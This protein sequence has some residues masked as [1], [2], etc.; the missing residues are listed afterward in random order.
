MP[1]M[2]RWRRKALA[3]KERTKK[4]RQKQ[5]KTTPQETIL[6]I[7]PGTTPVATH[8]KTS[9]KKIF[10]DQMPW[11]L[12][13]LKKKTKG[14]KVKFIPGKSTH[15]NVKDK[16]ITRVECRMALAER[17]SKKVAK[18][19]K[20]IYRVL[21]PKGIVSISV[22]DFFKDAIINA[23]KNAGFSVKKVTPITAETMGLFLKGTFWERRVRTKLDN[24]DSVYYLK[25]QK[26]T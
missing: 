20:E 13:E 2:E 10:L 19:I 26:K 25:F 15:I 8:Y 4:P 21:K 11:V 23:F 3:K 16:S 7:G 18:T 6:E 22:Q 12:R 1:G 5:P 17:G 9:K 24:R 14:E